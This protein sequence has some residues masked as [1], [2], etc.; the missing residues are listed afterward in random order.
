MD[1]FLFVLAN[2]AL[3]IRPP[4]IVSS[5]QDLQIYLY[6]MLACLVFAFPAVLEQFRPA[7]LERRPITLCVLGL[8]LM[9]LLSNLTDADALFTE[10]VEFAKV[11]VYYLLLVAVVNTPARL[12]RF[13]LCLA[14]FAGVV[15]LLA[16]LD[17]HEVINLPTLQAL[18]DVV[19]D[20]PVT[21][22]PIVIRRLHGTGLFSDPNDFSQLL[23]LAIPLALYGL[24]EG[25]GGPT[26]LLWLAP[27]GLFAYALF[28]TKSRGGFLAF[29]AGVLALLYARHGWR[30]CL[31][32]AGLSLPVLL[33]VFAGRMTDF[34]LQE[35]TGQQR[36]QIWSDA[37]TFFR[38]SPLLGVGQN[39]FGKLDQLEAHNSFLH[40]YADLGFLGGTLFLGAFCLAAWQ[41]L[42]LGKAGL[43]FLD[44]GV[45]RLRPYLLAVV[46]GVSVGMLSLSRCYFVTTYTVLGL[47][48]AYTGVGAVWPPP[49]PV[50]FDSRLVRRLA[51]TGVCFLAATYVFVRAF[52]H[53]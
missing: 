36:I 44:P 33:V 14:A 46:V 45:G 32:L 51:M 18:Q 26:R 35:G 37:L 29:V 22:E 10:G 2:A 30:R 21:G 23:V 5:W 43:L 11:V 39:K 7:T 9:G 27:L 1:F 48:T 41:L 19:G 20:D 3:F 15:T 34:S 42:R 28:L 4:E 31:L 50:I 47:T 40:G 25:R 24:A 17:Y 52:M 53:P 16:V 12:R 8:L 6:L 49:A 13:L 38:S